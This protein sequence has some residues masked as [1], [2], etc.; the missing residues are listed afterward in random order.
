MWLILV[1]DICRKSGELVVTI[2][3]KEN[4]Y[5]GQTKCSIPQDVEVIIIFVFFYCNLYLLCNNTRLNAYFFSVVS[6]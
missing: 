4:G 5:Y 2:T 3:V 6:K 1:V